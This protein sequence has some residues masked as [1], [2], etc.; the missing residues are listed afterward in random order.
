MRKILNL[1]R[2]KIIGRKRDLSICFDILK[3]TFILNLKQSVREI[4]SSV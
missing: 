2:R 3:L 1:L 4:H